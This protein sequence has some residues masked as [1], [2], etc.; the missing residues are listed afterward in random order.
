MEN[1]KEE[2]N[3]GGDPPAGTPLQIYKLQV[4]LLTVTTTCSFFA[5]DVNNNDI[6]LKNN[7]VGAR[8]ATAMAEALRENFV[9]RELM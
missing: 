6:S 9:V 2:G 3:E 5:P 4:L 7:G 8:G 1:N